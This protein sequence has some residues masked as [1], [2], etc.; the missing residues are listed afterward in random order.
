MITGQK[1]E[2]NGSM[3]FPECLNLSIQE[4]LEGHAWIEADHQIAGLGQD[5]DKP[6]PRAP[7]QGKYTQST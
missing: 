4:E 7:G 6:V 2:E 1:G 5:V 3:G